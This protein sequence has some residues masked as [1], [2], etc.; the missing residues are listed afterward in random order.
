MY[1]HAPAKLATAGSGGEGFPAGLFYIYS[2]L[3]IAIEGQVTA[4]QSH[5]LSRGTWLQC[6]EYA[7]PVARNGPVIEDVTLGVRGARIFTPREIFF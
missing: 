6:V 3:G 4:G 2:P 1:A 7:K 5:L